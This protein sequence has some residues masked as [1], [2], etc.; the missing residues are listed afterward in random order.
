MCPAA[1]FLAAVRSPALLAEFGIT[2]RTMEGYLFPDT[3][4]VPVPFTGAAMAELMARTFF[5]NRRA[6]RAGLEGAGRQGHQDTVI[7]ASIVER[8]YR[9]DDEAP[10][11]ASV[12]YNRL[13]EHRA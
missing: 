12:F 13:K 3:Y 1:D 7:M 11:I 2:G 6:D 5:D 4:F 10:L 9:A 8:E